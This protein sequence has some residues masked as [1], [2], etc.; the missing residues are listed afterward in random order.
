MATTH[1]P[2]SHKPAPA[3][4]SSPSPAWDSSLEPASQSASA[5]AVPG[6]VAEHPTDAAAAAD[7]VLAVIPA[8]VDHLLH[9]AVRIVHLAVILVLVDRSR[10][11]A[12]RRAL[13]F[14]RVLG[15]VGRFVAVVV[16][17]GGLRVEFEDCLL[18]SRSVSGALLCWP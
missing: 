10:C 15:S 18:G 12:V 14:G 4:P 1:R 17:C 11:I 3:P 5:A 7:T 6:P 16:H 8:K 9:T 13:G 2:A